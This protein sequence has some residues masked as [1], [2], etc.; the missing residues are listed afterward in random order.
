[1][2]HP[3]RWD[4][5]RSRYE[6][7]S[8]PRKMLAIDGGGIRGLLTLGMLERLETLLRETSRAGNDYR[9]C[10]YFDYVAG[11]STGGIIA[12][13]LARG[14]SVGELIKFYQDYGNEIFEKANILK[15]LTSF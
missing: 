15:R 4:H 3:E 8:Q 9:L 2:I 6:D 11:T 5:L 7:S 10:H 1:M 12:A 13:G 14:L